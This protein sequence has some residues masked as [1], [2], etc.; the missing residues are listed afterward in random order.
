MPTTTASTATS[1]MLLASLNDW[2]ESRRSRKTFSR[3]PGEIC[4]LDP[5]VPPP[6]I[7]HAPNLLRS[8]GKTFRGE[9]RGR[10]YDLKTVG[11][12]ENENP[13]AEARGSAASAYD[14]RLCQRGYLRSRANA[15][16]NSASRAEER[17]RKEKETRQNN[18]E[19]KRRT[20]ERKR[21]VER[22]WAKTVGGGGKRRSRE[23]ETTLPSNPQSET[24]RRRDFDR[25]LKRLLQRRED[26]RVRAAQLVGPLEGAGSRREK[27]RG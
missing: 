3:Q 10:P 16:E 1:A 5:T 13:K 2:N 26:E 22:V 24:P 23:R 9:K 4:S 12:A 20:G 25:V 11:R 14:S 6:K 27:R 8:G 15:R 18:R 7:F 17:K 19:G 21:N